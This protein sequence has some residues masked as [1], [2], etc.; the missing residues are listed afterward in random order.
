MSRA[1][2]IM[3]LSW[4]S[5]TMRQFTH[6]ITPQPSQRPGETLALGAWV[7]GLPNVGQVISNPLGSG[8][9]AQRKLPELFGCLG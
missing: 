5:A 1:T 7:I 8:L 2:M 9:V 6:P 3:V 4:M